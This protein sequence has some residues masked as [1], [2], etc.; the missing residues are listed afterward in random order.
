MKLKRVGHAFPGV[1]AVVCVVP[2]KLVPHIGIT[3]CTFPPWTEMSKKNGYGCKM[4]EPLLLKI[5]PRQNYLSLQ[6]QNL[7]LKHWNFF[8]SYAQFVP[9]IRGTW[10]LTL[11]NS[12]NIITT[13]HKSRNL[14]WIFTDAEEA[15]TVDDFLPA[16]I[17]LVIKSDIP[18]W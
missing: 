6:R 4:E 13:V 8:G 12:T 15:I 2:S 7:S 10:I 17:F 14:L 5:M 11:T 16:L 9:L 1:V 18:N 3:S